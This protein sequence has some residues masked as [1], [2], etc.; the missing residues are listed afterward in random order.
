[1][2][3]SR[4]WGSGA[5]GLRGR[6]ALM[7]VLPGLSLH[8]PVPI[9]ELVATFLERCQFRA[10]AT[11]IRAQ[12]NERV[13][14]LDA[15]LLKSF[16]E[17]VDSCAMLLAELEAGNSP[18][19]TAKT[20]QEASINQLIDGLMRKLMAT[21]TALSDDE[22]I[23]CIDTALTSG[24]F[25]KYALTDIPLD[26]KSLDVP[27]DLNISDA[28]AYRF[29]EGIQRDSQAATPEAPELVYTPSSNLQPSSEAAA[30]P[31]EL[32]SSSSYTPKRR[33]VAEPDQV[34]GFHIRHKEHD[35]YHDDDDP[36][37]R[38]REIYEVEL[39]AELSHKNAAS[40]RSPLPSPVPG[41]T[42]SDELAGAATAATEPGDDELH[43]SPTLPAG[44][45]SDDGHRSPVVAD[46]TMQALGSPFATEALGATPK[47]GE[48]EIRSSS[49]TFG[50][51]GSQP[52]IEAHGGAAKDSSSATKA[53]VFEDIRMTAGATDQSETAPQSPRK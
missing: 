22:L 30:A 18:L 45:A 26:T 38:I 43:D 40:S 32:R 3:A 11:S 29:W 6:E 50:G 12:C 41:E 19:A 36:G 10:A 5:L 7:T 37:Y 21:G 51:G 16:R 42:V 8:S 44:E 17:H 2:W 49:P 9:F 4:P 34:F 23:S 46:V 31:Q 48:Q 33:N 13:P 1:F 25:P 14:T 47:S 27:G 15:G 39:L 28:D 24:A 35:E 20:P 52:S 53:P